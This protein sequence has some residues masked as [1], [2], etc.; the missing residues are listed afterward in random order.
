MRSVFAAVLAASILAAC[1]SR[2][3]NFE[4]ADVDAFKPGVTTYEEV[5]SKL[6]KPKGQNFATDGSK[7][8]TW[9]YAHASLAG[10]GAKGTKIAFDKDGK[11]VRI[12]SKVE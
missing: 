4:M 8:V 2:G 6:G 12:M 11:M 9:I 10:S 7:T 1:A 3:T 5:V